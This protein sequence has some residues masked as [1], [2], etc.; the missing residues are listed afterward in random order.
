MNE[1]FGMVSQRMNSD[2]GNEDGFVEDMKVLLDLDIWI[3]FW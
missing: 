1:Q 3:K 2:Q